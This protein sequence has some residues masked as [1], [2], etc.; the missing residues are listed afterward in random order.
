MVSTDGVN[1]GFYNQADNAWLWQWQSGTLVAGTVPVARISGLANSATITAAV[2]NTASQIVLRDTNGDI[3]TGRIS[4]TNNNGTNDQAN[5]LLNDIWTY[6]SG[7]TNTGSLYLNIN[8]DR[9]LQYNGTAYTL[10]GASLIVN[11]TTYTSS[12][13]YKRDIR[14]LADPSALVAA[15]RVREFRYKPEHDADDRRR[16]GFIYEEVAEL[17]PEAVTES[18]LLDGG[19][20]KSVDYSTLYALGF[21]A[22]Q[23]QIARGDDLERRVLALEA[24]IA[25]GA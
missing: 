6:R 21:R 16:I 3:Y 13:D 4:A 17:Y 10:G 2:T 11:G 8:R 23:A 22:L 25:R 7:S 5:F 14:T 1:Q 24:R 12:R 9:A 15:L 19:T 18:V 20:V